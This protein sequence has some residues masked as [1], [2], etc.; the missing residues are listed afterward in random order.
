MPSPDKRDLFGACLW[1][2]ATV[3]LVAASDSTFLRFILGVPMVLLISGHVVL[4]V[5][6]V[7]N[8]SLSEHLVC[9]IGA[10]L[11]VTIAGG[12]VLNAIGSLTPLG[13]AFWYLAVTTGAMLLPASGS[14]VSIPSA[15]PGSVRIRSRQGA[16]VA[17][18]MLLA[19]GAY[20]LAVRDEASDRQFKY[21]E[22]W[23][24]PPAKGI[25]GQLVVGVRSAETEAR[26]YDLEITLNG[27]PFAVFRSL[28]IAPGDTWVRKFF[29]PVLAAQQNAEARLYRPD[30]NRL[31]R[32]VSAL[33]PGT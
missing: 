33:V 32:R 30:D 18:A 11:A 20:A 9:S 19:T 3:A 10:S 17:L 29:V 26:R 2:G 21:T 6:G 28:T 16:A 12:F 7:R 15:W 31:Y 13:W 22:L 25:P 23:M 24:L 4:R 1:A 5:I 14:D 8:S 27:Q